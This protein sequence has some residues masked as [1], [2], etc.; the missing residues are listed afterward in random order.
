MSFLVLTFFPFFG[1]GVGFTITVLVDDSTFV[2]HTVSQGGKREEK[3]IL[4]FGEE[5]ENISAPFLVVLANRLASNY[6]DGAGLSEFRERERRKEVTPM[7]F[8]PSLLIP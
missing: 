2:C 7:S 1:V 6:R 4:E 5:H 3:K 8:S